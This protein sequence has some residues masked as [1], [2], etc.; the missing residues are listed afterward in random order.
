V[1]ANDRDPDGQ[2]IT[3]TLLTNVQH[4][5]LTFNGNGFVYTP[6]EGYSGAEDT[7]CSACLVMRIVR[8]TQR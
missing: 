1:L 3:V 7:A 4:G 2:P 5:T 8:S 6:N